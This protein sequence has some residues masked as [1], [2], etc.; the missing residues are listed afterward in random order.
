MAQVSTP[1]MHQFIFIIREALWLVI[2]AIRDKSLQ[3]TLAEDF[4]T[5]QG[6][7]AEMKQS[8]QL[9]DFLT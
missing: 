9:T 7:K 6:V 4:S 3:P 5:Q 1:L 2:H 8:R